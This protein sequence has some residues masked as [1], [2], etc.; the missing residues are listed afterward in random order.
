MKK[1]TIEDI[2]IKNNFKINYTDDNIILYYYKNYSLLLNYKLSNPKQDFNIIVVNNKNKK[3]T[4]IHTIKEFNIF[5]QKI[6][7]KDKL[8]KLI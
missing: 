4:Y 1:L 5:F 2:F 8:L 3:E 6:T 7:R